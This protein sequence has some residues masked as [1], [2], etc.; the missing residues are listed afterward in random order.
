MSM[1]K[2]SFKTRGFLFLKNI[3]RNAEECVENREPPKITGDANVLDAMTQQPTHG[4]ITQRQYFSD[5]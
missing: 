5:P 1:V 3:D 2:K 4:Y